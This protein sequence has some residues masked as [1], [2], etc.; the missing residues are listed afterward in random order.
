MKKLQVKKQE[1]KN[2]SAVNGKGRTAGQP[3]KTGER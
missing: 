3:A 1:E 2:V